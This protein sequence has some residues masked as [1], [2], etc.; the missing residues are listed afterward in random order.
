MSGLEQASR[1]EL[2]A[3]VAAQARLIEEQAAVLTQQTERIV[4]LERRLGRNSRNSRNSPTP[5]SQD[6]L[7][8]AA[9]AFDA[10]QE[11]PQGR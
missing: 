10:P 4:E 5:P 9:A 3:V 1:N 8:R 7:E 6:G 11:W 2:L